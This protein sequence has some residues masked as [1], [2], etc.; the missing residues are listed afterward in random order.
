M[1][2]GKMTFEIFVY[3]AQGFAV[4]MQNRKPG[5]FFDNLKMG[6]GGLITQFLMAACFARTMAEGEK[7]W[8]HRQ[9]SNA[10]RAIKRSA[11]VKPP[12]R[13]AE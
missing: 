9:R 8:R 5:K 13:S 2:K 4:K 3:R 11:Q 1:T 12:A 7:Q 6:L 10:K